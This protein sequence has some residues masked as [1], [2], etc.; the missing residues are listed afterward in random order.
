MDAK[1]KGGEF[2]EEQ[3]IC[4]ISKGLTPKTAY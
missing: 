1:S 4:M 3:V 2:D